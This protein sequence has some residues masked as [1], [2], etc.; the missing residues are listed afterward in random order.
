MVRVGSW[1]GWAA[2]QPYL[3]FDLYLAFAMYGSV[4]V[5][6]SIRS[7]FQHSGKRITMPMPR[8]A[9][10]HDAGG[11]SCALFLPAT[12]QCHSTSPKSP[13]RSPVTILKPLGNGL[14]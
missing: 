13:S 1:M 10:E 14:T 7:P 8:S 12:S 3:P 9:S 6:G 5:A 11:L 2:G 4:A